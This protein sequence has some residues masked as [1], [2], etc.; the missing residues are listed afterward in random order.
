[1]QQPSESYGELGF[2][3]L[4]EIAVGDT[5]GVE[6]CRVVEGPR[7]GELLAVKRLHPHIAEDPQFL[8]MFRDEVWMTA[9]L[10]HP[11]VVEVVGWGHDDEGLYLGVELVRGVSLARLSKTVFETGE[12]FTERMV[13]Y[14]ASL[15]CDGLVTAH[16]LR[17]SDGE[18]LGL[19]HRDLTPGN[20]LL[21][22]EGEVKITDFGLAKA[23]QRLTKTL[24]GLLKGQPQYMAPEQIR[25]ERLDG[26]TDIFALGVVLFELFS[27]RR[28]WNAANDLDAMRATSEKPHDD[29]LEL[30][31]KIDKALVEVVNHCLE[32][33]PDARYQSATELRDRL[34]EWLHVHGYHD[35][36]K[37]AL[38]RFVRR[39]AMRQMRWFER[40]I[41]G[42]FT[43]RQANGQPLRRGGSKPKRSEAPR[44]A[45]PTASQPGQDGDEEHIDW[46]EDGPTLIQRSQEA[47]RAI[48]R[49]VRG[50]G[51]TSATGP[52]KI[53]AMRSRVA[54]RVP[55][56]E[57]TTARQHDLMDEPDGAPSSTTNSQLTTLPGNLRTPDETA[58][59]TIREEHDA[60]ATRQLS[61]EGERVRTLVAGMAPGV[62][63]PPDPDVPPLPS[64]AP[65][66][67]RGS[68]AAPPASTLPFPSALSSDPGAASGSRAPASLAPASL[69][70][71]SLAP[72][73]LAPASLAPASLAPASLA[74]LA[75]GPVGGA[76]LASHNEDLSTEAARLAS[77]AHH[78]ADAARR[79]A[80]VAAA[81]GRAASLASEAL[82]LAARGDANASSERMREAQQLD[83]MLKSGQIPVGLNTDTGSRSRIAI[84]LGGNDG[85]TIAVIA[86][87]GLLVIIAFGALLF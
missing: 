38:A 17:G 26:R 3:V 28:P 32:K 82:V 81:A 57:P 74:S 67:Q 5:A 60:D 65:P 66:S 16:D 15:L 22:F 84:A 51:G 33:D 63:A 44:H 40:A 2:E 43:V 41:A 36:N 11:N 68:E 73:S 48:R 49:A 4:A 46:G 27:G 87:V 13:V 42:E 56:S 7:D 61:G 30:R 77:E 62:V 72:A 59:T 55:V 24:T 83:Q 86:A 79:A 8:D 29:L 45:S 1:M 75:P 35:G 14:V 18:L 76:A 80:D 19:V 21:G 47:K 50:G 69:A 64:D 10:K 85:V 37:Q 23:K 53:P 39:N 6:L 70:P 54:T 58:A 34:R 31:P 78:A 25:A 20:V 71:A 9:A 12:M 52:T